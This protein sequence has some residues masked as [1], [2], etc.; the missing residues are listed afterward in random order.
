MRFHYVY[1][2]ASQRN[3][4]LYIGST[5]NLVKRIWEHKNKYVSSFTAKYSVQM[6]V[7]YEMHESYIAAAHQE[8]RFKNWPRQWKLN[9]IERFNPEWQDLY[10]QIC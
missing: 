9:L 10:H 7:Y 1:I 2:L 6:L 4:T 5:R 8:K 3:G